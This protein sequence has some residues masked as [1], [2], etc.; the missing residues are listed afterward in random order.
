MTFRGSCHCG[1]LSYTVDEELPTRALQCNCS[2][3]RRRAALHHFTTPEKFSFDG[4]QDD[5]ASYR[6][7]KG[8]V[9]WE[10]CKTCGCAPF[11]HGRG[12][13]G[14]MVEI[15]VR[16]VDGIELDKLEI[17]QFDGAHKLPGPSEPAPTPQPAG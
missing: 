1:K 3:C 5:V 10:F 4:S 2:I 8:N 13:N 17:T 9:G 11:A 16:C 6:W 7:N 15:N 14:P 12:S